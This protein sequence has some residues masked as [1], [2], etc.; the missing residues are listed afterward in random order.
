LDGELAPTVITE[1]RSK[2]PGYDGLESMFSP[3]LPAAAMKRWPAA[4]LSF[5]S[6]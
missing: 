3:S 1:A 2:D 6:S 5:I 4:S